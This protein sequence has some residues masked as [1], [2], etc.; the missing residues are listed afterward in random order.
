MIEVFV[1]QPYNDYHRIQITHRTIILQAS[2]DILNHGYDILYFYDLNP[3]KNPIV[4]PFP[5]NIRLFAPFIV[6]D[7]RR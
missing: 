7:I 4:Q 6:M 1:N 2:T 3:K 5:L